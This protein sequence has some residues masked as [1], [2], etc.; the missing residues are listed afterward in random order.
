MRKI[1]AML[2]AMCFVAAGAF[3]QTV[4]RGRV[5]DKNA[6]PV[7]GASVKVKGSNTGTVTDKAGY[8]NLPVR[9]ANITLIISSIGF[10]EQELELNGKTSGDVSLI[11]SIATSN[12]AVVGSRSPRRSATETAVPVDIIPISKV[13]NQLGQV[14]LNQ[15]LQFAAPSFN[16]NRQS[17]ADGADHVDPATLRGLGPDQ[18]L[19]LI[20]GKRRHQSSLVNLYGSRG[21]GNT[22]TDLN[23]IPAAAIERIEILR[24]GASAQYG[25]DAIAGVINVVLKSNT[26]GFTVNAMAGTN[27]TGYGSTL[28]SDKGKVIKSTTDGAQVSASVNYGRKVGTTGFINLTGDFLRKNKTM[29]PN[30]QTLYPDNFRNGFGDASLNNYSFFV[31]SVIPLKGNASFYGFAGISRRDGDAFAYTRDAGS[32][33]NVTAIYPNGFDPH[34][35]SHI[36]DRSIS[37]GVRTKIGQVNA[38][39]NLSFGNN[40]FGYDVDKTLNASLGAASPTRFDAGGFQLNQN[41]LG[42]DFSRSFDKVAKGLNFAF[43][44]EF[45]W[46]QYN[47]FAGELNSWKTYRNIFSISGTDTTF[48]PGGSQG[49]PGF[50]PTDETKKSRTNFAAYADAELDVTKEWLIAAAIRGENYSDFGSTLNYKIATRLK[51]IGDKLLIR[52][53]ASTG[54]RAPSLPQINFSSTFTNVVAGVISDQVISPNSGILARSVGIAPLKQ[55]T[56]ENLSFGFTAKPIRNLSLTVDAYQVKIKDRVVLTGLFDADDDAIGFILAEQ[57]VVAAQF[58]TNAANTTTRGVDIIAAYS[59]TIGKGRL[60]TTLAANFNDINIDKI[61]TT[62]LLAGKEEI[63]YSGREQAF[64]KA[65]A[66][67]HKFTLGLDY[68]VGDFSTLV[69][70]T[71]FAGIDIV[72]YDNVVNR[73]NSRTTTDCS[74]SYAFKKKYTVTI[75]GNNI[76]DV[77]PTHH[78][79]GY[80][81][82]GGMWEATQMGFSG[83]FF[84]GRISVKL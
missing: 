15:I 57:N 16:S 84:F 39:F 82:T 20:N 19:V 32:E 25:S 72:N 69:R 66:P 10:A 33:R 21:R 51:L 56:S 54:F 36:D 41:R 35:Q 46:E 30:Y 58:F 9:D 13:M 44:T 17:G 83:A 3:A 18:T 50:R 6:Q 26:D 67:E 43:G 76:L 61:N 34:I 75:G 7:E 73:Y 14:D 68:K 29:R 49:F 47:I 74:F 77:Y 37:T 40:R 22:G 4:I 63:Y 53:S 23:A 42:A 11:E 27:I 48:R 60:N 5:L 65:S 71:N 80:T 79:P 64:L 8:Y 70:L 78:D 59:N 1:T 81:E 62:S 52:G 2:V 45:R 24:D 12:V 38:D 28:E 55:E 31:N